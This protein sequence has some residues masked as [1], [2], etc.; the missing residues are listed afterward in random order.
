MV[1]TWEN[2]FEL[3][4]SVVRR[5]LMLEDSRIGAKF[6]RLGGLRCEK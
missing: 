3:W 1:T 5:C 4:K 6:I 2:R